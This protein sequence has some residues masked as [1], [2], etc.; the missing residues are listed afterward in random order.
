MFTII[1]S[2]VVIYWIV[3]AVLIKEPVLAALLTILIVF[4]FV[5]I[6]VKKETVEFKTK[7][8][9]TNAF[10]DARDLAVDGI[11]KAEDIANNAKQAYENTKPEENQFKQKMVKIDSASLNFPKPSFI[12]MRKRNSTKATFYATDDGVVACLNGSTN[13][14]FRNIVIKTHSNNVRYVCKGLEIC[15]RAD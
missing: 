11:E 13:D 12:D 6:D 14:C 5:D 1:F 2:L 8:E 4:L 15:Y 7:G 9:I 3:Q 10:D